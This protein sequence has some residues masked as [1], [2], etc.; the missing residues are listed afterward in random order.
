MKRGI[1]PQEVYYLSNRTQV[2]GYQSFFSDPCALPS[3]VP[4]GSIL[5]PLLFVLFINDLIP[6]QFDSAVSCYTLM[7]QSF[8][9]LIEMPW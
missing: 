8:S 1:L 9:S 2:V 7:T 3:G 5:G 4:Q 6:M